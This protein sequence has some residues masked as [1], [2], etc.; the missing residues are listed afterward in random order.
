V[1]PIDS[2]LLIADDARVQAGGDDWWVAVDA[3]MNISVLRE[4]GSLE[5]YA[6]GT[7]LAVAKNP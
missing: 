4:P 1:L 7:A 3:R 6:P 2:L 5:T